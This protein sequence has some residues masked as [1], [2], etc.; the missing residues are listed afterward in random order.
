MNRLNMR[1][2][3][4]LDQLTAGVSRDEP[5]VTHVPHATIT[6]TYDGGH[7]FVVEQ[8]PTDDE[9]EH[10]IMSFYRCPRT[11]KTDGMV[12]NEGDWIPL[13]QQ[14]GIMTV[15]VQADSIGPR[16]INDANH[17]RHINFAHLWF[18]SITEKVRL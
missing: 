18:G 11:F 13:S 14:N 16:L 6:A 10:V 1:S 7:K 8:E 12:F 15:G 3:A 9:V 4:V 17:E 5:R 2:A